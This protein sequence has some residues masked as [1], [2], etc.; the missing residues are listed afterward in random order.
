M[1][2][3]DIFSGL[4]A[5]NEDRIF[6]RLLGK[7][8]LLKALGITVI[9]VTHAAHR[10]SYADHIIALSA[11]GTISEQG[12]F[13]DLIKADGYV[14]GLTARHITKRDEQPE[15]AP[16]K[17]TSPVDT[18]RQN[19]AADL[20]RPVASWNVYHYYFQSLGWTNAVTWAGLMITYSVLLRFPGKCT[21]SEIKNIH[22]DNIK[23]YG[24]SFGQVPLQ[25]TVTK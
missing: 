20:D 23:I 19:A 12:S 24:S 6:A 14:N 13:S 21:R 10:L 4:D 16:P 1:I 3:D 25:F 9:L 11:E 2:L 17:T 18:A 22:A 15:G 5:T 8:G 7:N